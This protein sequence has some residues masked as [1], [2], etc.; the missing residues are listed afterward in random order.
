MTNSDRGF[1]LAIEIINSIAQEYGWRD[2]LPMP[3]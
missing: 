1:S 2:R 3:N